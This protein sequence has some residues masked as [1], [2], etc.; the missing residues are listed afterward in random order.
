MNPRNSLQ[1]VLPLEG[2]NDQEDW[3]ARR[4]RFP[5]RRGSR[6]PKADPGPFGRALRLVVEVEVAR[7][8]GSL[9]QAAPRV[10][11]SV[12]T[13][14]RGLRGYAFTEPVIEKLLAWLGPRLSRVVFVR[15]ERSTPRL[16]ARP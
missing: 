3:P 10:G 15:A 6:T 12:A 8:H 4:R 5:P 11:V 2:M 16:P 14:S 9:Q 13:L 1:D 7:R